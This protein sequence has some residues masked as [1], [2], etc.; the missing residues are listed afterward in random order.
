VYVMAEDTGVMKTQGYYNAHSAPQGSAVSFALPLAERAAAEV[1]F[2]KGAALVA[3]YGVAQGRN[4]MIPMRA[5]IDGLRRRDWRGPVNVVHTDLPANDFSTLFETLES[6]SDSYLAGADDVFAYAA[7]RSF[8]HRIFASES[9]SLGW[10]AIAVHWL[11]SVPGSLEGHIWTSAA[12]GATHEEFAARAREDWAGF[13]GHRAAELTPG[14]RL[15]VAGG[16]ADESGDPGAN[17]LMDMAN[18][19]LREMAGSGR[20]RREDYERMVVPTYN[21]TP[22]EYL[23][24]FEDGP[25]GLRLVTWSLDELP[26]PYWPDFEASGDAKRFGEQWADFFRAAYEPSLFGALPPDVRSAL[27]DDFARR[28]AE[29]AAADP[30]AASCRWRVM[31]MLIARD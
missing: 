21:R 1:A 2:P 16:A 12:T 14:G 24:G 27:A 15:V 6:S 28:L 30:P 8:Y 29:R 26:D 9:V 18:E 17:G 4:S 13:L 23:A 3:D 7:G 20:L 11:S 19:V 10:S 22:E 31:N 5:L 25:G